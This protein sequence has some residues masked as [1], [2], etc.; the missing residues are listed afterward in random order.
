MQ[1]P[2]TTRALSSPLTLGSHFLVYDMES[3]ENVREEN[4]KVED[5]SESEEKLLRF[6]VEG[7]Y[8]EKELKIETPIEE[9][10]SGFVV[11]GFDDKE[12]KL[13][14]PKQKGKNDSEVFNLT[15]A[16]LNTQVAEVEEVKFKSSEQNTNTIP[17][18]ST[19]EVY[20]GLEPDYIVE[21][22]SPV[23]SLKKK[24][25]ALDEEEA[26]NINLETMRPLVRVRTGLDLSESLKSAEG[27]NGPILS[28][29]DEK[30]VPK[31]N[32]NSSY[33]EVDKKEEL[34]RLPI[35]QWPKPKFAVNKE[36]TAEVN[37]LK[38]GAT[39]KIESLRKQSMKKASETS[40]DSRGTI[41]NFCNRYTNR[42]G[43]LYKFVV[44]YSSKPRDDEEGED[45]YF[46]FE[47]GLGVADG[48]SGW[49]T[50]GINSSVFSQR[51]M[52][53][54]EEEIRRVTK[55]KKGELLEIKKHRIPKVASYVGLDFQANTIYEAEC[56]G[57]EGSEPEANSDLYK[58]NKRIFETI[59]SPLQ[60]LST[61]Y[62]KVMEIGSSTA[63]IAV[64]NYNEV[65]AVNLGDSGFMHFSYKDRQ[66]YIRNVSKEQQHEFNV[67]Y[68]LARVPSAEYL[69]EMESEGRTREAK[70]LKRLLDNNKICEDNPDSADQYT[71]EVSEGD[72]FIL[73]TDGLF[74]NIF[75]YEAKN[76]V[77]TCMF[78]VSK[79]TSRVAKVRFLM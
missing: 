31:L 70:Q 71:Y 15:S 8:E 45:S 63:T 44:G 35:S 42:E 26:N 76:I 34:W 59:I 60:I 5:D 23:E 13:E 39:K 54:C 30:Q 65:E 36:V 24:E 1:L 62:S 56:S 17:K 50:Y 4:K 47:R 53:E 67:P 77:N 14:L 74:D 61:A 11:G 29:E 52:E 10:K 38:L 78:N 32:G 2:L 75:S 7:D 57:E 68:Q 64:L 72:I 40:S 33:A 25:P 9:V 22:F 20:L 21:S 41:Y 46:L 6:V 3:N 18:P 51:L 55:F 28:F 69:I 58:R 27:N 16:V 66:Y 49:S 12:L 79:I 43:P 48:V 73:G 37:S 19:P